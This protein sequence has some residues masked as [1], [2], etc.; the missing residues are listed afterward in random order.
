MRQQFKRLRL[1]DVHLV[2]LNAEQPLPFRETFDRILI[3]APCSGTG[4]LARHPE[5][6]W[7]LRPEQLAAFHQLQVRLLGNAI[8]S[9]KPGGQ[10]VYSTC[11]MEPE[12]NEE[13]VAEVLGSRPA[14]RCLGARTSA[15]RLRPHLSDGSLA[16]GLFAG[17]GC[18]RTSPAGQH[19]D[20]F[21]AAVLE[22]QGS[23]R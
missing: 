10:I 13:V 5:I 22:H 1:I 8:A 20:G 18:F 16:E 3:D 9:L 17:D 21:F 14:I 2:E 6:R 23:V 15:E 4:T 19:T 7:R 12:E 11:S